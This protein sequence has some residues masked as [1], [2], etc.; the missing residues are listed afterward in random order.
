MACTA[1]QKIFCLLT[2]VHPKDDDEI[3]AHLSGLPP[4]EM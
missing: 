1:A 3:V 4:D 2:S